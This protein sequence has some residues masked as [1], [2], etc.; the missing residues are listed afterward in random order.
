MATLPK[1]EDKLLTLAHEISTGFKDNQDLYPTPPVDTERLDGALSACVEAREAAIAA[2]AAARQATET[3]RAALRTLIEY[4]RLELRY[5][6]T[7]VGFD[8]AK[9]KAIGWGAR[10]AKTPLAPP[11]QAHSLTVTEQGNGRVR[12][13]WRRPAD[14]GK[15]AAY[16]VQCRKYKESGTWTTADMAV[17]T[18]ITLT[19]QERG[20]ELEYC[21]AAMNKAG[22]GPASNIVTVVL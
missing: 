9:L 17:G 1:Q 22:N 20:Q 5:A 19:G 21:V 3:K 14:G 4:V 13:A 12:L 11:G 18:G 10:R 8:D 2:H 6:E 15:V 16:R 7:A